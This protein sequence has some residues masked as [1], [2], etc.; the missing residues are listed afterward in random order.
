MRYIVCVI[1]QY[2]INI[3]G[4]PNGEASPSIFSIVIATL[5][6]VTSILFLYINFDDLTKAGDNQNKG[7]QNDINIYISNIPTDNDKIYN[8]ESENIVEDIENSFEII[9][10]DELVE[11]YI[12]MAYNEEIPEDILKTLSRY[13]LYLIRNGI[14]AYEG[15]YFKS[16]YYER[17]SWYNGY[18]LSEEEVWGKINPCQYINIKNIEKIE[19]TYK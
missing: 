8:N 14:Y 2:R 5:V 17:F 1:P 6:F 4:I 19:K 16:G 11:K 7:N 9:T 15:L 10:E 13:E 3:K 12:L 18:I